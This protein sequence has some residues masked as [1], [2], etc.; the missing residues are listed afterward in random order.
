VPIV[1]IGLSIANAW[2]AGPERAWQTGIWRDARIVRPKVVFGAPRRP[3]IGS[4]AP[5]L[6]EVRTYVIETDGLRL[7]LKETTTADA[8]RVDATIGEPV[9]FA[10]EK[11]FVYI[12]EGA[13]GEHRLG[14]TKR[15]PKP[16]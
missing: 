3:P 8:P 12:K 7:E 4:A 9:T 11:N 2:A 13:G 14:V 10:L 15:I 5:A 16:N 1:A 6:A